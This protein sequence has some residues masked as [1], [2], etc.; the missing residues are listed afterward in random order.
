[1]CGILRR[2]VAE[3]PQIGVVGAEGYYGFTAFQRLKIKSVKQNSGRW[4]AAS[5][6]I[7]HYSDRRKYYSDAVDVVPIIGY[8]IV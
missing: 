7:L 1:M 2:F 3:S 8:T 5:F 6:G 4:K